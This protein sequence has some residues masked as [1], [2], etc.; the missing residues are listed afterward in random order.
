VNVFDRFDPQAWIATQRTVLGVERSRPDRTDL[1]DRRRG[2]RP[3]DLAR[4]PFPTGEAER[5]A[6]L[7]RLGILD[8]APEERFDRL[9]RLAA[10][11]L[12]T[13][14]ALVSL[15]DETRQW[16][17]ARVG[18][19]ATETPRE[20]AFCAHA[21]ASD[22]EP[23]V[24]PDALHDARFA[25]NP[26]VVGDP[27]IRFY[28]GAV[29]RDPT[30]HAMGTL[31]AID[32]TPRDLSDA[33]RRL[34]RDL[35]DLAEHELAEAAR[36]EV[37]AELE[38][39]ERSKT[40]LLEALTDGL[41]VQD[42]DGRIVEWNSAAARL[43]GLTDDELAG[44][45]SF[46]TRWRSVH[47]DGRP[48]P[49]DEH[50]A[51]DALRTGRPVSARTMGVHRPD[52]S[53]I[54][55]EVDSRPILDADGRVVSALTLFSDIAARFDAESMSETLA[56]QLRQAIDASGIGTAILDSDGSTVFVNE[57]Y[58]EIVGRAPEQ[59]LGRPHTV[60]VHPD[61]ANGRGAGLPTLR[62]DGEIR[63]TV[64][65]RVESGG[66]AR[67][68]RTHVS[69]L[70]DPM[71]GRRFIIQLEDVT[72][73]RQLQS[74]LR[75][76]EE[77]A[78][79]S[80]ESLE[81]G[82]ILADATGTIHQMNPA[83]V[84]ILGFEAVEL[85]E[86]FRAGKWVLY[87]EFGDELAKERRPNHRA[88]FLGERVV[89][90]YV[91]WKH[92]EGRLVLLRMSSFPTSPSPDGVPRVVV[93]FADVTDQ[94]RAERLLDTTMTTAPVGIA[95]VDTDR[96]IVR[97][98]P[99]FAAH[100]GGG[101][102]DLTGR[103]LD[104]LITPSVDVTQAGSAPA[105]TERLIEHADG[106]STWL[107]TR[108]AQISGRDLPLSIVA[109]FDITERKELE[110]N[111]EQFGHLFRHANDIITVVDATGQVLYASP[112]NER[113]LGYPDGWR[114]PGGVLDLVH[115]DDL[116]AALTEFD[117]LVR[118]TRAPEPFR[119]RVRT[120]DGSWKHMETL[121]TNLIDEPSVGGI[122][123]TSRD[124]TDSQLMSDE[125]A[126][127]ATHDPLT[128]LPNRAVVADRLGAALSRSLR[129]DAPV[130]LCYLDLDGFKRVNDT[131]GHA[132][133]DAVLVEVAERLRRA[134]RG[135]DLAARVG[136]DEFV[137]VLDLV[138]SAGNALD[139][140][141]RIHRQLVEPP[142]HVDGLTVGVSVGVTISEIDDTPSSLLSRA[143]AA[144]Y[145]VKGD[146]PGTLGFLAPTPTA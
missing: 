20:H 27:K 24:V 60:W 6:A 53:L 89:G 72:N 18:I 74:A 43:L 131:L 99:T 107:E 11:A 123:L 22:D 13:P 139:V 87:D 122:V 128:D 135:S 80:L 5:L 49:G 120:Q 55:L 42:T 76:S 84:R 133:G 38:Y 12:D 125:L 1:A 141:R 124:V 85:T 30:G 71:Q 142:V 102:D 4:P 79:T 83:A 57:A 90:E 7:E 54:W 59:L 103:A 140:A 2:G 37:V 143:D 35:A 17:K 97:N 91:G 114:S 34:L 56:L 25:A 113:V 26:L 69:R 126:H 62:P 100:V 144:L 95:I 14:I 70:E 21:I 45:T 15:I 28:A 108:A 109:T 61:D 111:L 63:S 106:S 86:R 33:Q 146:A 48:W 29:L 51:I 31:C 137:I 19:D 98:N 8:T 145:R 136:G 121:G 116:G 16:F 67:W 77:I 58:C 52:G 134:V 50:P 105:E 66:D 78:R 40:T 3:T 81:Q 132:A 93:A 104:E 39:S 23:F 68:V 73:Q 46:D 138:E 96:R 115:P 112:S 9:V 65:L 36:D 130:G 118:G 129:Q 47:A 94:R 44:R 92:A 75:H 10:A 64:D 32:R 41:V 82:V 101:R 119:M 88:L 127:R 110:R 117:A